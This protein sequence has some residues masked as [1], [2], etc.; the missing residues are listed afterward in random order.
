MPNLKINYVKTS[1]L[2]AYA[3]NAKEHPAE[4]IEQIKKSIQ[5]FGF[6]DPIA[7]WKD[8]EVIEG[9][10]RLIAATELGLD[11][12]PVINL[13][14]LTDAQRRAYMLAHNKLTMN[15]GFNLDL[16]EMELSELS[17]IDMSA[18]GFDV[19]DLESGE[20]E[21]SDEVSGQPSFN[22]K[23]QYGVIVMCESEADQERIYN[24]L[25]EEGYNCKVVAV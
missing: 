7:V 13:D 10:G 5:E 17:E 23:E 19:A 2:R 16:L 21:I 15:S 9:H 11:K 20:A 18:F 14:S 4:Q 22:Y 24:K 12:V 1:D 3:N 25:T 6:N 8:N